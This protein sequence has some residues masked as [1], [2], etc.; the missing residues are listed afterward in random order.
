MSKK[1]E[2]FKPIEAICPGTWP[3]SIHDFADAFQV[4]ETHGTRITRVEMVRSD[5]EDLKG[6]EFDAHIKLNEKT[7]ITLWDAEII[8]TETGKRHIPGEIFL[9]SPSVSQRGP[10]YGLQCKVL[11]HGPR[12]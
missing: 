7:E 12:A 3:P 5:F 8:V 9:T 2:S 10:L 11:L 4:A 1:A 6:P